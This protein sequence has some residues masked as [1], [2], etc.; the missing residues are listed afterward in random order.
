[1]CQSHRV[2]VV[3]VVRERERVGGVAYNII[4]RTLKTVDKDKEIKCIIHIALSF[5]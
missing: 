2:L 1:M 4:E 5:D 3:V